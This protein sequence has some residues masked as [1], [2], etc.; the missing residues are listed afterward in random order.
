MQF[1]TNLRGGISYLWIAVVFALL[2]S[3]LSTALSQGSSPAPSPR[4]STAEARMHYHKAIVLGE[5]AEWGGAV[6]ELN[7]ALQNEPNH[8]ELLIEL[9]IALGEL[10]EWDQAIRILKKAVE[11]APDSVRAHYNL[12]VTLD[13]FNPGKK[14]GTSEYQKALKLNPEDVGS[15]IN[16][17]ANLGDQNSDEAR[18]LLE[19]ALAIDPKNPRAHFNL[20]LLLKNSG[21]GSGAVE[22]LHK[23]IGLDPEP[24]EP[25]RHLVSLLVSE[26]RWDETVV[27]CQE[28]L[29]RKSTDWSA[30]YTLGQSLIRRSKVAEGRKELEKSQEIRQS[31]E[32][33]EEVEKIV[34]QGVD[35]LTQGKVEEGI[36]QFTSALKM[37][38][39]SSQAHMYLG[40]ALAAAGRPD[41][42]IE[43][44]KKAIELDPSSPRAHHNLG[45]VLMQTGRM[46]LA[47][48]ELEKALRLDP[49]FPETHNN[50][51]LILSRDNQAPQGIEHFRL[52]SDLNPHY[53]EALFNLGLALRSIHQI[54]AAIPAF[55]RAAEAAPDNPEVHYALSMTLK[56]KGDLKGAK[57]AMDRATTLQQ[58]SG[59]KPHSRR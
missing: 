24:L 19:R 27:Q 17:A 14:P 22:E 56:D 32:K 21:D 10:E 1:V 45:T 28:I 31:Q 41:Q 49:Y 25:R 33:K 30:R 12:G 47:R 5:K 42:G 20:A 3:G 40:V 8:P 26:Q 58:Q 48:Q 59:A 38:Q 29:K 54:D 15:L 46:D 51:G 50:L 2:L 9:G 34:H 16:L 36:K 55:R 7:R 4:F 57:E 43:E 23:A 52:A 13:R 44:L 37:D 6:L 53:L 18:K 39:S 35:A 11:L